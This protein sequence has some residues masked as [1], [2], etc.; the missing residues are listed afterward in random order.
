MIKFAKTTMGMLIVSLL[1]FQRYSNN[2]VVVSICKDSFRKDQP[3]ALSILT[4]VKLLIY[5]TERMRTNV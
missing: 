5:F 3:G 4:I 1:I 2:C